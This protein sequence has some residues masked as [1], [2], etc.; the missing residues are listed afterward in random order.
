MTKQNNQ[1]IIM[2]VFL[3]SLFYNFG[4]NPPRMRLLIHLQDVQIP[5]QVTLT[6][7]LLLRFRE[8]LAT[9]V[10]WKLGSASKPFKN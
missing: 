9:D 3:K 1:E 10:A 7:T 4:V 8:I 5:K 6:S 2:P